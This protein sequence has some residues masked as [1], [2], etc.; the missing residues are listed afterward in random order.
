MVKTLNKEQITFSKDR[1]MGISGLG[2]TE[3]GDGGFGLIV[4][5][6]VIARA[7]YLAS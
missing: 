5:V 1:E 4:I 6:I 3:V 7:R 2:T